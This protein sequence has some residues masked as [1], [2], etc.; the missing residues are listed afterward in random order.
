MD[1]VIWDGMIIPQ[2]AFREPP[3]STQTYLGDAGHCVRSTFRKVYLQHPPWR[4]Y[5]ER[6]L[7]SGTAQGLPVL[8]LRRMRRI[9][10]RRR[11]R[12]REAPMPGWCRAT[13]PLHLALLSITYS[14]VSKPLWNKRVD[15]TVSRGA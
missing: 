14:P 10:R 11:W 5:T 6:R 3:A 7:R 2:C 9:F 13:A 15:L 8:S 1:I 4:L 12:E